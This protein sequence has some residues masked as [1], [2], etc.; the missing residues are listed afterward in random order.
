MARLLRRER[1]FGF[2]AS[3]DRGS[4]RVGVRLLV[5]LD[6]LGVLLHQAEHLD[7]VRLSQRL[8]HLGL[9][10]LCLADDRGAHRILV[11]RLDA[12]HLLLFTFERRLE[13]LHLFLELSDL[14][15]A[16]AELRR[17]IRVGGLHAF[18]ELLHRR[19]RLVASRLESRDL[20]HLLRGAI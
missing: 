11:L 18:L 13:E 10:E 5:G 20:A 12:Q 7:A 6:V 2:V 1:G 14:A 17:E 15:V 4:E 16:V 19:E 9:A 3:L 8:L